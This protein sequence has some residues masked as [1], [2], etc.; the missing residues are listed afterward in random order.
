M[1]ALCHII[2]KRALQPLDGAFAVNHCVDLKVQSETPDI[3]VRGSD[4][5]HHAVDRQR[6]CMQETIVVH[7]TFRPCSHHIADVRIGCPVYKRMIRFARHHD[8]HIDS[9]PACDLQRVQDRFI[10]DK[11][12]RLYIDMVLCAVDQPQ[13]IIVDRLDLRIWSA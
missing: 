10:R 12:R 8:A 3:H 7:I 11:I 5:R 1:C 9:R 13:V 6:L 2:F 4:T